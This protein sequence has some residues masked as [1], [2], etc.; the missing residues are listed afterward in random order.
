M[1]SNFLKSVVPKK[2]ENDENKE[3]VQQENKEA[4]KIAEKRQHDE[5]QSKINNVIEKEKGR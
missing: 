2:E 5:L 3:N 1:K 4:V